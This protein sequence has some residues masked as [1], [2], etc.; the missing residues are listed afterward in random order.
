MGNLDKLQ[1]ADNEPYRWRVLEQQRFGRD[2]IDV[3]R[4]RLA[5]QAV[6]ILENLLHN[7]ITFKFIVYQDCNVA[8]VVAS[9]S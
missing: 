9:F 4:V 2:D 5:A 7:F 8:Q 3:M 1:D 6:V